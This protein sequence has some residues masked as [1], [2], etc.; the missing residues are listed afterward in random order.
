[1]TH[2]G[3]Q[4]PCEDGRFKVRTGPPVLDDSHINDGEDAVSIQRTMAEKELEREMER[5]EDEVDLRAELN[6]YYHQYHALERRRLRL[7]YAA[8]QA[9]LA[10]GKANIDPGTF[11]MIL[12][13]AK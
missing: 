13:L 6:A 1:M 8:Q 4:S 10:E 11:V 9:V 5:W 2:K 12:N 7:I 3:E